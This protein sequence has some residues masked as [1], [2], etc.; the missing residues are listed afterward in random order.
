ME[1][2]IN[3]AV[4]GLG[5]TVLANVVYIGYVTGRLVNRIDMLQKTVDR[6][7]NQQESMGRDQSS[8]G[9][10]LARMEGRRHTDRENR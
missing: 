2:S 7:M 10:R 8:M 4:I 3:T 6:L 5:L 1:V 9:E